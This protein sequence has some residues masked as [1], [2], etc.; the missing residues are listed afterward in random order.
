[1]IDGVPD[2]EQDER[3]GVSAELPQEG[4]ALKYRDER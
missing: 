3:V 4:V 1:M 2:K